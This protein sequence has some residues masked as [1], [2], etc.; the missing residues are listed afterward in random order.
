[1]K[2]SFDSIALLEPGFSLAAA[3]DSGRL[4]TD[5]ASAGMQLYTKV[6]IGDAAGIIGV[7][8]RDARVDV[9]AEDG[10]ASWAMVGAESWAY[11]AMSDGWWCWW[12]WLWLC[13]GWDVVDHWM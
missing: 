1:L 12:W 13:C 8:G 7:G 6:S 3:A 5:G 9:D 10:M 11:D 4:L 2:L